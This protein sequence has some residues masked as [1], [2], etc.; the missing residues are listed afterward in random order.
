MAGKYRFIGKV[1]PRKDAV[2]ILTGK[3]KFMNDIKL[4]DMLYGRC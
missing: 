3:A 2:E 1:T 4:P